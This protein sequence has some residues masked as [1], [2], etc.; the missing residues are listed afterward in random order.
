MVIIY[1]FW[2]SLEYELNINIQTNIRTLIISLNKSAL[3]SRKDARDIWKNVYGMK[4]SSVWDANIDVQFIYVTKVDKIATK[5]FQTTIYYCQNENIDVIIKIKTSIV[6]FRMHNKC[7]SLYSIIYTFV[8]FIMKMKFHKY[9]PTIWLII[10]IEIKQTITLRSPSRIKKMSNHLLSLPST[11]IAH[12][13][14]HIWFWTSLLHI[15][16]L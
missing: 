15:I 7:C 10:C 6:H 4:F 14:I 13:H 11:W 9:I 1:V 5:E 12:H 8:P 3:F 2:L 16:P